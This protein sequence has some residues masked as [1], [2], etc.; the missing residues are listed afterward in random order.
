MFVNETVKT[1]AVNSQ[2]E[3]PKADERYQK[4]QILAIGEALDL[5]RGAHGPWSDGVQFG[6]TTLR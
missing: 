5:V 3:A 4:P 2:P 1:P 6:R